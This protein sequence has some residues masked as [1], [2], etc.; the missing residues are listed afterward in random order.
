MLVF[1]C[2]CPYRGIIRLYQDKGGIASYVCS[3]IL[4]D[5][6][7][8]SEDISV[9][10]LDDDTVIS[11]NSMKAWTALQVVHVLTPI[12]HGFVVHLDVVVLYQLCLFN[13]LSAQT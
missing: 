4:E 5:G 7:E 2:A 9:L 6:D 11:E 13:L 12:D 8:L 1:A 3:L 10:C